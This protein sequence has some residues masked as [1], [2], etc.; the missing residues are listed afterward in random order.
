MKLK[1]LVVIALL[2]A[3]VLLVMSTKDSVVTGVVTAKSDDLALPGVDVQIKGTEVTTQTDF[4]GNYEI[5]AKKGD[6]LV[7]SYI[8]MTTQEIKLG[9]Q[10]KIDVKL[11]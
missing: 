1:V 2:A 10:K 11:E 7:F 5:K 9:S 6:V 3:P 4:D 8:K